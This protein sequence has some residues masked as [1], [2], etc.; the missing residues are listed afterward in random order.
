MPLWSV[1]RPRKSAILRVLSVRVQRRPG[2]SGRRP[3][4]QVPS[5]PPEPEFLIRPMFRQASRGREA[6]LGAARHLD[7]TA[8]WA[9][10]E[11]TIF[12]MWL[13][14]RL[15]P[16]RDGTMRSSEVGALPSIRATPP[17]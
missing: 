14:L 13:A 10:G 7:P 4:L 9:V 6:L 11:P 17:C 3:H 12:S 16:F 1:R 2:L 8:L 15:R 5:T